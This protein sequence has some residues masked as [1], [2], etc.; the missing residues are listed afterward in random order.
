MLRCMHAALLLAH[1]SLL[2]CC[3]LSL[4]FASACMLRHQGACC[5]RGNPAAPVALFLR[6]CTLLKRAACASLRRATAPLTGTTATD[7]RFVL[8]RRALLLLVKATDA[9]F[10]TSHMRATLCMRVAHC[11]CLRCSACSLMVCAV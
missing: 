6:A 9:L 3:V 4:C 8:R 11:E 5:V 10:R 2:R 7:R 1:L